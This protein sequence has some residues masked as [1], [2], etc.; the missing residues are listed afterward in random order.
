M[1]LSK[2][3]AKRK[4]ELVEKF[5]EATSNVEDA[6]SAVNDEIAAVVNQRLAGPVAKY[7][8]VLAE[9]Q[10][11]TETV[12]ADFRDEFDSKSERWQESDAGQA[13][14]GLADEWESVETGCD[15]E[16]PECLEVEVDGFDPDLPDVLE[17]LP[18]ESDQ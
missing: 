2:A 16:V 10:S 15:L 1:R 4:A 6:L 18:D 7:N 11:F 8:A 12:G 3:D 14:D 9:V 5:R 13:A 17:A